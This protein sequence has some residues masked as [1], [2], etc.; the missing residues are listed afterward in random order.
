MT[1]WF[2]FLLSAAS[3]AEARDIRVPT[4]AATIE[5]AIVL[6]TNADTILLETN[7]YSFYDIGRTIEITGA[8]KR[9]TIASQSTP[10]E[11]SDNNQSTD[12]YISMNWLEGDYDGTVFRVTNGATL[13][14]R[15]VVFKAIESLTNCKDKL[16]NDG[17]GYADNKDPAC[18]GNEVLSDDTAAAGGDTFANTSDTAAAGG[19]GLIPPPPTFRLFEVDR[20]SLNLDGVHVQGW[21]F[22]PWGMALYATDSTVN[23]TR[24]LFRNNG[25]S[26]VLTE[27]LATE[28]GWG[29]LFFERSVVN[30]SGSWFLA[31]STPRGGAIMARQ[32]STLNVSDTVFS[33]NSAYDGGAIYVEGSALRLT[34]SHFFDNHAGITQ[35]LAVPEAHEGGAL[36]LEDADSD[37]R[38]CVFYGND[39]LDDGAA[40]YYRYT[41]VRV[42]PAPVFEFN[43]LL[44]NSAAEGG[45]VVVVEGHEVVFRNNIVMD[46]AGVPL[47][48]YDWPLVV[49]PD[50][51]YNLYFN[52]TPNKDW[53]VDLP[54]IYFGG[55][56]VPYSISPLTSVLADPLFR[57]YAPSAAEA[58]WAYQNLWLRPESPARDAADP[59]FVDPGG[60]RADIGAYGGE[61]SLG[62]GPTLDADGDGWEFYFDCND[63]DPSVFPFNLE[64]CDNLDNDCNGI[65][66]DYVDSWWPD[67]DFDGAGD[68]QAA[69]IK[70]C[71]EDLETLPV[72][73]GGATW[74]GNDTDCD[75]DDYRRAPGL[76]EVCDEVDN[77][78]DG[79]VDE[80]ISTKPHYVDRDGDGFGDPDPTVVIVRDC[81]PPGFSPFPTDC[82]DGDPT[83]YP[84]ITVEARLHGPLVTRSLEASEYD[85]DPS[86]VADGIDQDCDRVDLCYANADGDGYGAKP[87]DGVPQLALDND[88]NCDN[89]GLTSSNQYDC[90]DRDATAFPNGIEK[91][92]DRRDSDCNG[93][94]T[95]YEDLDGDG[96]GSSRVIPDS[97]LDCDNEPATTASFSGD[98]NDL[99]GEG[100]SANPRMEE[101]CDG[102][103]NNCDGQI[104]EITSPDSRDYYID[105]D[106]D[107]YGVVS[108]TIRACAPPLGYSELA[109]DCDDAES[110]AYP[111]ND[112]YCDGIDNNCEG[113]VDENSAINVEVWYEDVDG[114]GF[115]NPE[116][117]VEQCDEPTDGNWVAGGRDFDCDDTSVDVTVCT[118]E[119]CAMPASSRGAART[120]GAPLL[121]L[122]V[123]LA[124]RRRR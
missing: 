39:T 86:F 9:V 98:C 83:R 47:T 7:S 95:C 110:R 20:G 33:D 44:K 27:D 19:G 12:V 48:A 84:L 55:D 11:I 117:S 96:Y 81:A 40:I 3:T 60:S 50:A 71:P 82:D 114:D 28:W 73:P 34:T 1:M 17:N 46:S 104:D 43:T 32:T 54:P 15:N 65:I 6:A 42:Q 16:D 119:G 26:F 14:L 97:D 112:E 49:P 18:V 41:G 85:R 107:G 111:G 37:V 78:C 24:S 22:T 87:I 89:I 101:V 72:L 70:L 68:S 35:P 45:S 69:V 31:N 29:A 102:L 123:G 59:I 61:G 62:G 56:L 5:E 115:G 58:V 99:P 21:W 76:P 13:T 2:A 4:D 100:A 64:P 10:S 79:L 80:E 63:E 8:N 118:C 120:L 66:D 75:D 23:I 121:A 91:P 51:D 105:L 53:T 67:R 36:Y 90:D 93:S 77:D 108:T 116:S 122:L 94:D 106:G 25:Q 124:R 109:G 103:D 113:G 52:N 74:V 92:A 88:L 30:V 57:L 38:N